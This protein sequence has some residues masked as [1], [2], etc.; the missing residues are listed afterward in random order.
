EK[1]MEYFE[2]SDIFISAAAVS[3]FKP[4]EQFSEKIKKENHKLLNIELAQNVDI[5]QEVG[6]KKNK[7][8]LIGF[9]AEATNLEKNALSKLKSKN[10]D[11]IIANDISRK[12]SGFGTDTNKVLI[13]DRKEKILDLPLMSKHEVAEHIFAKL[14]QDL[15]ENKDK[16][17]K[18]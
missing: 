8:I 1:V 11:Y 16:G 14:W 2:Y 15:A 6:K 13:I 7:Q 3:D 10:L 12:D 5:L 4:T 9:A 17:M 18:V